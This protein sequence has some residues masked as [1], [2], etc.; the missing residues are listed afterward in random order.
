M[1]RLMVGEYRGML[2]RNL[3]WS[4]RGLDSRS[5]QARILYQEAR[6]S[7]KTRR[8]GERYNDHGNDVV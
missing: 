4:D 1:K 8:Q 6:Q 3:Y 2:P 5:T 7:R